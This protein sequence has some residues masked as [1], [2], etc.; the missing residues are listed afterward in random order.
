M[1]ATMGVGMKEYVAALRRNEMRRGRMRRGRRMSRLRLRKRRRNQK[2][3]E[4][5]PQDWE[6]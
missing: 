4:R 5:R 6:R 2:L 1:S 3:V